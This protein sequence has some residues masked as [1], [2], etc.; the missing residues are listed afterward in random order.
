[1]DISSSLIS[2][3]ISKQLQSLTEKYTSEGKNLSCYLEKLYH[4]RNLDY[5]EYLALDSLLTLQKPKTYFPDEMI[6][7]VF[8]QIAELYFRLILWELEQ[9]T[10]PNNLQSD[11]IFHDKVNRVNR[12][13]RHLIK[14]FDIMSSGFDKKQFEKF[15]YGLFPASG[16]QSL[17][18]RLI[19]IHATDAHYLVSKRDRRKVPADL[20]VEQIYEKLYWK[21][22]AIEV[23]TE[24]KTSTLV[25]FENQFDTI[26]LQKL[27]SLK[28]RNLRQMYHRFYANSPIKAEI[29]ESLRHMDQLAN[30]GWPFAHFKAAKKNLAK[31]EG[32]SMKSTGGT[33]WKKYLHPKHQGISF[34]P[35]LWS[36]QEL[37]NWGTSY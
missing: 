9:L 16:F 31:D 3:D 26:L 11:D 19:E 14:S 25:D 15:R 23:T 10:N 4:E 7:I 35:K 6:F 34:F 36:A 8:H 13:Y 29:I 17:Q 33:N 22:G 2:P 37:A 20:P 21:R 30:I 24:E 12:Y 27:K 1:M 18:F 28:Y 32:E 5:S